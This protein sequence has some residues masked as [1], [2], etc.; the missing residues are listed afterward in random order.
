MTETTY[1]SDDRGVRIT[2][3]RA[4]FGSKT[5][6]MSNISSVSLHIIPPS[7]AGG[8]I[9]ALLSIIFMFCALGT[10]VPEDTRFVGLLA[11]FVGLGGVLG[12]ILW[13]YS[14]QPLYA[15]RIAATSGEIQAASSKDREYIESLINALNE[16]II[17]RG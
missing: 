2:N 5:Y 14:M 10:A 4:V 7:R 17:H 9:V 15:V 11:L 16:A 8:C 12:G 6:A 1:Y 13:M 3:A